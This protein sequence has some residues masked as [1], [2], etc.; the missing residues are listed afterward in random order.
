MIICYK[1]CQLLQSKRNLSKLCARLLSRQ[2]SFSA[3]CYK[4]KSLKLQKLINLTTPAVKKNSNQMLFSRLLES[5]THQPKDQ[6]TS[7]E[8]QFLRTLFENG[9]NSSSCRT[10]QKVE[11]VALEKSSKNP[12]TR[13]TSS[14]RQVRIVQV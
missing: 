6:S 10:A 2:L 12:K 14:S 9:S 7:D 4:A 13:P 8:H 11:Q 1:S 3:Q 5:T